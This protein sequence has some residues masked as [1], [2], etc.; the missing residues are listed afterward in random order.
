MQSRTFVILVAIVILISAVE[1]IRRER[2]TFKYA[3]SWLGGCTVAFIFS[4][5]P[6]AIAKLSNL[7]GF[8][9][10]SNF[11]FFSFLIFFVFLSLFLTLYIDEQSRRT[12]ALAQ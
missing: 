9:I 1:L 5:F 2:L 7:F 11:V 4:F 6:D 8:T 3:A 10:P 12:E